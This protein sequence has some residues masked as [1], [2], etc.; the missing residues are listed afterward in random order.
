MSRRSFS[1]E[2]GAAGIFEGHELAVYKVAGGRIN[3]A[4]LLPDFSL[5]DLTSVLAQDESSAAG[6]GF[7]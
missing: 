1:G 5:V 6:Q 4:I 2:P 3:E 7:S